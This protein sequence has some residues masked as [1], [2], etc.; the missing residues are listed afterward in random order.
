M[1][2][3]FIKRK[4]KNVMAHVYMATQCPLSLGMHFVV[5]SILYQGWTVSP[6]A[7]GRCGGSVSC[8][9]LGDENSKFASL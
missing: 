2:I 1:A 5:P 4:E 9:R 6:T 3:W 7:Y 8:L